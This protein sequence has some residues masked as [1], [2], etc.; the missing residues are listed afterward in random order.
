[1]PPEMPSRPR[2]L[3]VD[4]DPRLVH[5]VSLYLQVQ[6]LEVSTAGDGEQA[7][8]ALSHG[9][10]DLLITDVMMPVMDGIT[11]CRRV[12]ALPGAATLPII[13]FTALDLESDLQAARAAGAD[14]VIIKPFNL[15]GL[16]DAVQALLPQATAA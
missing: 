13:V 16:G 6:H 5:I 7:L 3:L 1:M 9:L 11:L 2:V 14:R 15:T 10:P 12:R 4:D 8:E